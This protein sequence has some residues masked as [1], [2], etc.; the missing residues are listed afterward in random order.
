MQELA[1]T[2]RD[3]SEAARLLA[4]HGDYEAAADRCL[5]EGSFLDRATLGQL[6]QVRT[7]LG[8]LWSDTHALQWLEEHPKLSLQTH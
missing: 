1:V 6:K 4:Q 5:A 8:L 7:R 3:P 2:A